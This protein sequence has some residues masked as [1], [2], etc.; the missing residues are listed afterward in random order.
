MKKFVIITDSC[1][2]LDKELRAKYDIQYVPMHFSIDGKDYVASL[3]WDEISAPDFY[4]VMR[5][6]KRIMTAQVNA[7][8][9]IAAFE[10]AINNGYDVLSI[11]C[12]AALS[13]SVKA[14][15][16]VRDSL[17]E[18]Y[19]DAKII[20]IDALNSCSGLG[21]ICI[22]AAELRSEG[23]SIEETASWVE[24][25]KLKF[26]QEA[27]VDKLTYL[28]QAGRVSAASAFFGGIF[29]VKP[30]I[31]SDVGGKNAAIEKVKGRK[32]SIDRLAERFS[33]EYEPGR[34]I[35]IAHADCPADAEL[36]KEAILGKLE[37]KNVSVRTA[38][39]GPIVG[40]SVGPGTIA[41]YF[42]GKAV[43]Y[44]ASCAE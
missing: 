21:M 35:V 7:N 39:I 41:V 33:E 25:N 1:S 31:I 8:D 23:K 18:K 27:T 16:T 2:D 10:D 20:C 30:I 9:Y 14:S 15:Y 13:A 29:N 42:Y 11:S 26:N 3:D 43:S 28:K 40:A 37:N 32:T 36:L 44:D 6:G 19:P 22:A 34:E 12:S 4:N 24:E 38:Y 5:G 17:L